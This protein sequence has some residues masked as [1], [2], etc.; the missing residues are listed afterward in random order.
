M[1]FLDNYAE[2]GAGMNGGDAIDCT[3]VGNEAHIEHLYAAGCG[4]AFIPGLRPTAFSGRTVPMLA[5]APINAHRSIARS[6]I[7]GP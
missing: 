5:A 4:G 3:F 7:T 2:S 1:R 6:W